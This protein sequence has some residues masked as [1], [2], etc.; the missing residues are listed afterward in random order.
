MMCNDQYLI[1]IFV[2]YFVLHII[3]QQILSRNYLQSAPVLDERTNT[4]LGF[5][6]MM[7][8]ISKIVEQTSEY[9]SLKLIL[10]TVM[11]PIFDLVHMHA[12]ENYCCFFVNNIP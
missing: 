8:I 3:T 7:D 12:S 9:P 5:V 10:C 11:M 4:Y 2:L 1:K 6:D